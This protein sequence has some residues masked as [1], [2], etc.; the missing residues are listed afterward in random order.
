MDAELA[1]VWRHREVAAE[2][3]AQRHATWA[4]EDAPDA[5]ALGLPAVPRPP[6]P[7]GDAPRSAIDALDQVPAFDGEDG[8]RR[9]LSR[10][11]A[12][13]VLDLSRFLVAAQQRVFHVVVDR[14]DEER[15]ALVEL[16]AAVDE[17]AGAVDRIGQRVATLEARAHEAD[18]ERLG[19]RT[20]IAELAAD[21]AAVEVA[22]DRLRRQ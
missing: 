6:E 18:G 3:T 13:L 15:R 9:R 14:Q 21:Q 16:T 5:P 20:D 12:S 1:E 7:G 8:W 17:L 2:R 11:T 22:V 19:L 4:A 10:A